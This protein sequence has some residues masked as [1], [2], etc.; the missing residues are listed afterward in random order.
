[1]LKLLNCY[2]SFREMISYS[3]LGV[4][5]LE[6][7]TSPFLRSGTPRLNERIHSFGQAPFQGGEFGVSINTR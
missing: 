1:M 3:V 6:S 4:K 7:T 2:L 5:K